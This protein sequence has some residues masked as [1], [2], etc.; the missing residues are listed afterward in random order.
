MKFK[1]LHL[2]SVF[3]ASLLSFSGSAQSAP[4]TT[5]MSHFE[6]GT[7]NSTMTVFT[8]KPKGYHDG[9]L[10][11][12]FHGLLRN[13]EDYCRNCIPLAEKNNVLIAAPLFSTNQYDNEEYQRG[14]VIRRGVVQPREKWSYARLPAIIEAVRQ[15]EGH[16][17]LPYYFL[18]H[19]GGGQFLMRLAAL[20]PMEAKRIVACNP[21]SDLF[22]RNDWKFG[23]GY[24]G[25]PQK[26]SNDAAIQQYLAAPLVLCLG[27]QDIDPNHPELDRSAAAELE[28]RC[29][30]ERGRNC[31]DF[32]YKLAQEHSWKFSW[33]KVEVPG[34]AHDGKAMLAA[35]EIQA[36]L[37]GEHNLH[38]PEKP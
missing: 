23:Y 9:P 18:G 8:Y 37:F 22:P 36:A 34:I 32:A 30:L 29:R 19:S 28:G 7:S 25:L 13:A 5:G 6:V 26:L 4:I 21:G 11:V 1:L 10:V 24:G 14:G 31:F 12:V 2:I 33:R 27:L 35:K 16:P 3:W 17:D 15:A 38:V 20:Y